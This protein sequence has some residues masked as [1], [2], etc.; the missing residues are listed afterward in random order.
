MTTNSSGFHQDH[1]LTYDLWKEAIRLLNFQIDCQKDNRHFKTVSMIYYKMLN[2]YTSK[3]NCQ[4]YFGEKI[5]NNLFYGMENEFSIYSYT[6]PKP[7]LGLRNYKFFT[8]PMRV[9]YYTIGIY[10]MKISEEFRK[11]FLNRRNC[12]D[13][14]GGEVSAVVYHFV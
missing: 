7:G 12:I 14:G 11:Q 13:L 2:K 6:I 4:S 9:L 1:F 10:L 8:Y 3:M 5:S